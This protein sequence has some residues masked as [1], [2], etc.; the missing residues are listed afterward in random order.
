MRRVG[1]QSEFLELLLLRGEPSCF[2]GVARHAED[3]DDAENHCNLLEWTLPSF[4]LQIPEGMPSTMNNHRQPSKPEA[5]F[6]C[7]TP[8]AITLRHHIRISD[9]RDEDT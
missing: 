7:P 3:D 8:N 9:P 6:M 5:P 1:S 2:L 4:V